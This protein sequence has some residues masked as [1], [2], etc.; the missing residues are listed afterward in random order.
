[1]VAQAWGQVVGP[2]VLA[3]EMTGPAMELTIR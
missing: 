3:N 1:M 2:M